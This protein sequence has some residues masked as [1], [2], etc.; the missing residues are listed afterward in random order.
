MPGAPHNMGHHDTLPSAIRHAMHDAAAAID[1]CS[2][3]KVKPRNE[4]DTTTLSK[5][6]TPGK[7]WIR[8]WFKEQS[9]LLGLRDGER[10]L[11]D[12]GERWRVLPARDA[13]FHHAA[14]VDNIET[15]TTAVSLPTALDTS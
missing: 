1:C 10:L 14:L 3:H 12:D 8:A 5:I 15:N 11:L 2:A 9:P 7:G 4:Q 13:S 6:F